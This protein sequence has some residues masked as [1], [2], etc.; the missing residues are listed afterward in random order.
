MRF[1]FLILLVIGFDLLHSQT[2]IEILPQAIILPR[3]NSSLGA[4]GAIRFNNAKNYFEGHDGTGW[5]EIQQPKADHQQVIVVP[6]L[7]AENSSDSYVQLPNTGWFESSAS[8]PS[9]Y[10]RLELPKDWRLDSLEIH[11]LDNAPSH[12]LK[13]NII[14]YTPSAGGTA[15]LIDLYSSFTSAGSQNT[16]QVDIHHANGPTSIG[17]TSYFVQVTATPDWPGSTLRIKHIRVFS[18]LP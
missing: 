18:S 15:D 7:Q 10:K 17:Q 4:K 2:E 13:V 16:F 1:T 5:R 9:F 11:Y 12:E 6:D 14:S 8:S 3:D